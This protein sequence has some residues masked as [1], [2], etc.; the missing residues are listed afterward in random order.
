MR[1]SLK[2]DDVSKFLRDASFVTAKY[3]HEGTLSRIYISTIDNDHVSLELSSDTAYARLVADCQ[4][5]ELG[6][7]FVNTNK[8]TSLMCSF[9]GLIDIFDD[10]KELNIQQN[11][12]RVKLP[13][14][15]QDEWRGLHIADDLKL[16]ANVSGEELVQAVATTSPFVTPKTPTV[17]G[18]ICL[19]IKDAVVKLLSCNSAAM[20][21][22]YMTNN[23]QCDNVLRTTLEVDVMRNVAKLFGS[24]N[25]NI[26]ANEFIVKFQCDE[27]MV[28]TR[29]I[30]GKYPLIESL[31]TNNQK[32]CIDIKRKALE[33]SLSRLLIVSD[34]LNKRITLGISS[35]GLQLSYSSSY[36]DLLQFETLEGDNCSVAFNYDYIDNIV[37]LISSERLKLMITHNNQLY[38]NDKVI[39]I[40]ISPLL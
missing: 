10:G 2:V 16:Y 29:V 17:A 34:K 4:V 9:T 3:G 26:Y 24:K 11:N 37:R 12:V 40:L 1:I 18:G 39:S 27:Y 28:A 7:C 14:I 19:N 6:N 20:A 22:Y 31:I 30:R 13:L 5:S 33:E 21:V 25:I 23:I 32:T 8:F 35:S 15:K 38:I 36:I